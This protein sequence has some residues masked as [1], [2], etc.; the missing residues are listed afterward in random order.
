MVEG[1]FGAKELKT[2]MINVISDFYQTE[3]FEIP[4]VTVDDWIYVFKI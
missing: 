4:G 1:G 3:K 2:S